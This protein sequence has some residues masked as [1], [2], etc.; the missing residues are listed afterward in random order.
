MVRVIR[1][2]LQPRTIT[3][4]PPQCGIR[5]DRPPG[6]GPLELAPWSS[7]PNPIFRKFR[8]V[9]RGVFVEKRGILVVRERNRAQRDG[10]PYLF[11]FLDI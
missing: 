7:S 8:I 10:S 4:A 11:D 6:V 3:A 1:H 9:G 5:G 2:L